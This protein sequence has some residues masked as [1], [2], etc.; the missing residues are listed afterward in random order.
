MRYSN[1]KYSH[2]KEIT[3]NVIMH[4]S[5]SNSLIAVEV[6][7]VKNCSLQSIQRKTGRFGTR[8]DQLVRA[9]LVP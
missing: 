6:L 5:R 9:K 4:L 7:N 2:S 8:L 1:R 3:D